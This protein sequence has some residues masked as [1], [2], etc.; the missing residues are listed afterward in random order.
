MLAI[1]VASILS[2]CATA[3][4]PSPP[5]P[6]PTR[7][8]TLPRPF[9]CVEEPG[10]DVWERRLRTNRPLRLDTQRTLRRGARYLPRIRQILEEAGVPP[11]LA[12]LPA[13]ESSFWMLARGR[14]DE[15]GLWQLRAGT[16]RRCGLVVTA[17]RDDRLKLEPATYCAARYL[18]S[19][20]ARY[21]DWPLALAAY[22]AGEHRVDR[23]LA[24]E[25]G[26][27]FWLLARQRRLPPISRQYVPRFLA[28]VRIVE[29]P[30]GCQAS[31][32]LAERR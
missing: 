22:N 23:A 13:V 12:L 18:R 9:A 2:G 32:L 31:Q 29:Q 24:R 28:V 14:L 7:T 6:P 15:R 5:P 19:L 4:P 30:R 3:L 27:T 16:A 10:V 17:E 21:G 26:A 8:V 1:A 11:S 25:P 20:H